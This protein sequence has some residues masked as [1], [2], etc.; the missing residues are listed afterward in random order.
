MPQGPA[1]ATPGRDGDP[2]REPRESAPGPDPVSEEEWLAWC[3][4]TADEDE[5]PGPDEEEPDP[6]G[7]PGPW[8][9]DLAQVVAECRRITADEAVHRGQ[10]DAGPDRRAGPDRHRGPRPQVRGPGA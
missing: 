1:P 4:A 7:L 2:A 10:R 6:D 5:P 9:Y 8:E 3:A